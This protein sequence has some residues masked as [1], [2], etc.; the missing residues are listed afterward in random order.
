MIKEGY[1]PYPDPSPQIRSV[2]SPFETEKWLDD[3]EKLFKEDVY[4]RLKEQNIEITETVQLITT[5]AF[6][7]T[8]HTFLNKEETK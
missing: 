5:I 1:G 2:E 6:A 4:K 3:K 7:S 8:I